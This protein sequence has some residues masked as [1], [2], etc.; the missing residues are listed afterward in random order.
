M[1]GAEHFLGIFDSAT[2]AQIAFDALEDHKILSTI[3]PLTKEEAKK[4]IN[5]PQSNR[6]QVMHDIALAGQGRLVKSMDDLDIEWPPDNG[7]ELWRALCEVYQRQLLATTVLERVSKLANDNP[8]SGC[9]VLLEP[10][11]EEVYYLTAIKA[12]YENMMEQHV[13]FE[14]DSPWMVGD[15]NPEDSWMTQTIDELNLLRTPSSD[16][17]AATIPPPDP[18]R[19]LV[20]AWEIPSVQSS[21]VRNGATTATSSTVSQ[22]M[23]SS[24]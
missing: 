24:S 7:K 2:A 12:N 16:A 10:L 18:R 11:A 5:A 3:P 19:R 8:Q 9:E 20:T 22:T 1:N 4:I 13:N 17:P 23:D 6:E 21:A 15:A 14:F